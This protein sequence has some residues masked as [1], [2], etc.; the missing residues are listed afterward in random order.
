MSKD[1]HY[2][3]MVNIALEKSFSLDSLFMHLQNESHVTTSNTGTADMKTTT[4]LFNIIK[5]VYRLLKMMT[6]QQEA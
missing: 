1:N 2:Y 5:I 3:V 6:V 4:Y